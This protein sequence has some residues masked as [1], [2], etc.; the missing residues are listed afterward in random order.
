VAEVHASSLSLKNLNVTQKELKISMVLHYQESLNDKICQN[1][2]IRKS[3]HGSQFIETSIG[4]SF[5]ERKEEKIKVL[6]PL[7]EFLVTINNF[8]SSDIK[9][10]IQI[11]SIMVTG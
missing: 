6:L 4:F 10:F 3:K 8:T 5:D 11:F 2:L 1:Y 7:I 9:D